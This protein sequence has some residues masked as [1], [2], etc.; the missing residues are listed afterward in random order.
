MVL[1]G[2]VV[3]SEHSA[4]QPMYDRQYW[5]DCRPQYGLERY[6]SSDLQFRFRGGRESGFRPDLQSGGIRFR[7]FSC[8]GH[9]PLATVFS[10]QYRRKMRYLTNC[11]PMMIAR[12][13]L[14]S[15]PKTSKRK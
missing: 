8:T 5:W 11:P 13:I 4:E 2:H 10:T 1:G 7:L 3:K 14:G 12:L 9:D 15:D 6:N